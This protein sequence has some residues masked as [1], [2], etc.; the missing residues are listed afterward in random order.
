[1]T[2][3]GRVHRLS[4]GKLVSTFESHPSW[5]GIHNAVKGKVLLQLYS[6][7]SHGDND[8]MCLKEIVQSTGTNANSLRV[9]LPKW[10]KWRYVRRTAKVY[11]DRAVFSYVIDTRGRRFVEIRMPQSKREELISQIKQSR[12]SKT[13]GTKSYESIRVCL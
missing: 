13:G 5:H 6:I 1:M 11:N 8:G 10:L 4:D 9:L 3:P 12:T 2:R 7:W